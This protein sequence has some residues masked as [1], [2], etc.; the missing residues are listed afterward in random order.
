MG[1]VLVVVENGVE[2]RGGEWGRDGNGVRL[3]EEAAQQSNDSV[4]RLKD[5]KFGKHPRFSPGCPDP[6][7]L[8]V[9]KQLHPRSP[10]CWLICPNN[11][12]QSACWELL[13]GQLCAPP[14]H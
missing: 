12:R 1:W 14:L 3:K 10:V 8:A 9:N 2:L 5:S 4:L 13:K 6:M 7:S 11:E